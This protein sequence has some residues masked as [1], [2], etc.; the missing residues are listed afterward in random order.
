MELAAPTPRNVEEAVADVASRFLT[1]LPPAEVST[2]TRLFGHIQ[3]AQWFYV[4]EV[5]PM[6]GGT[7]PKLSSW[8]FC[9]ILFRVCPMLEPYRSRSADFL[10]QY[11]AHLLTVPVYG[12][13]LLSRDC[14]QV[15]LVR[16]EGARSWSFPRGKVNEGESGVSCAVREVL[17]ETG[18]DCRAALGWTGAGGTAGGGAGATLPHLLH[19]PQLQSSEGGKVVTMYVAVGVPN[20]G[21]VTFRPKTKGEIGAIGW[22]R[23]AD[24][25]A[26][27]GVRV[28]GGEAAG[29]ISKASI[30]GLLAFL[31]GLHGVL[32]RHG[33]LAPL[34]VAGT[35]TPARKG[36]PGGAAAPHAPVGTA[37][38]ST[39]SAVGSRHAQPATPAAHAAVGSGGG[40]AAATGG[41]ASGKKRKGKS[42]GG[43]TAAAALPVAGQPPPVPLPDAPEHL[44][45]PL[46]AGV[47]DSGGGWSVRD[48]WATNA[49]LLRTRFVYDGNPHTFGDAAVAAVPITRAPAVPLTAPLPAPAP[50]G[51]ISVSAAGAGQPA[52]ARR[53]ARGGRKKRP[54]DALAHAHA[55][56]APDDG[57]ESPLPDVASPLRDVPPFRF[58]MAAIAAAMGLPGEA[59]APAF[60]DTSTSA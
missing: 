5:V 52:P 4:D 33:R 56:G 43:S 7:L 19:P 60:A 10:A 35:H 46:G 3:L 38:A 8:E 18:Y 2:V 39:A 27:A 45:A 9:E 55:G 51:A 11:K 21:S 37:S 50:P 12:V 30:R 17:E 6:A 26:A 22:F 23:L 53:P 40:A 49:A 59:T 24:L 57:A 13:I 34:A 25:F 36:R 47:G 41:A 42:K 15:L 58:D 48:M 32:V 44:V 20:D 29:E 28:G 14:S 54:A 16:G 31:P 1:S